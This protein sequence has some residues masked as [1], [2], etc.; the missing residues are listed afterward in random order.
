MTDLRQAA[1]QALEALKEIHPGNM[2]PM[3]EEAWNKAITAL[4]AALEQPEPEPTGHGADRYF[5]EAG[6][7]AGQR[8][9]LEQPDHEQLAGRSTGKF[10]QNATRIM[11]EVV[12]DVVPTAGAPLYTTPPAARRPWVGLT[13]AEIKS[14]AFDTRYGGLVETTR[15]IESKLKEKNT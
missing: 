11:C 15:A 9:A 2:T 1:E 4:R 6:F 14:I 13:D 12:C 10:W 7:H 5:Y 3:A 8:A